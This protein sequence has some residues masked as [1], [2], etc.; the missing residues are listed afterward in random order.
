MNLSLRVIL[1]GDGRATRWVSWFIRE[2]VI[3]LLIV[4]LEI[5]YFNRELS[6]IMRAYFLEDLG[7]SSG[8]N[9]SVFEVSGWPIHSK[10]LSCPSLSI[11]HHSPIISIN[12]LL[13]HFLGAVREN[14]LLWS[15]MHD[16]IEFEFPWLLLIIYETS[17]WILWNVDLHSLNKVRPTNS[18]FKVFWYLQS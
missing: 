9:S 1:D 11:T 13:N 8:N 6:V 10:C 3:D 7:D 2:Q 4:D 5:A 16:P 12:H 17:W 14:V 18:V 15:I